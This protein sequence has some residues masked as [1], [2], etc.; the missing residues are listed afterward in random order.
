MPASDVQLFFLMLSGQLSHFYPYIK[1]PYNLGSQALWNT[2]H[3]NA[4]PEA[5]SSDR[6]YSVQYHFTCYK[7]RLHLTYKQ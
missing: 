5:T 3:L 4:E 1:Y 2:A 7:Q 6:S